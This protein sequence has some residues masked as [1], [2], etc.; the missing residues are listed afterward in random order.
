MSTSV[1]SLPP[2]AAFPTRSPVW[3]TNVQQSIS[4]KETRYA[5]ETYP[6][7]KWSLDINALRS[8][9][10]LAEFQAILGFFNARQGQFD[11]FLYKDADDNQVTSQNIGT[12]DGVTTAF[13]LVR[14]F[15][16]FIEPVLGPTADGFFA[17]FDNGTN[18][19]GAST[20]TGWGTSTPGIITLGSAPASGHPVTVNMNY[21]WPCR[22]SADTFDFVLSYNQLYKLKKL[23]FISL[24]N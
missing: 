10:A 2:G 14:I 24:K 6:R 5:R 23:S 16:G 3:D 8:S 22:M 1:L 21:T 19:T 9:V 18:V 15:G 7:Y 13:Q 11:S 20:L 4:G 17:V 12:G